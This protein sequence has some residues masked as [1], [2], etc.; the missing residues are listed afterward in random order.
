ML[1]AAVVF[2]C[3]CLLGKAAS[4][5]PTPAPAEAAD[6]AAESAVPPVCG[7]PDSPQFPLTAHVRKGAPPVYKAD[8]SRRTWTVELRN[9]TREACRAIHPVVVIVDENR[10]L[11]PDEIRLEYYAPEARVWRSVPLESS[12]QDEHIGVLGGGFPG[13]V[14]PP[15]ET[16][17]VR[18]RMGFGPEA[19]PVDGGA[20][21]V[22]VK[23]AAVQRQR[24]DGEWVGESNDYSLTV[25]PGEGTVARPPQLAGTGSEAGTRA[26]GRPHATPGAVAVLLVLLGGALRR[27]AG[28]LSGRAGRSSY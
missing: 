16:V 22:E 23:V 14:V 13:F 21:P 8:G 25:K 3:A 19:V 1:G 26:D 12:D 4:A 27:L 15:T 10:T 5:A 24:D 2:A 20:S 7:D 11:R 9:T 6:P 18:I 28:A 17:P